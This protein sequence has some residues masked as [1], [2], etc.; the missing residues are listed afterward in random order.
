[1]KSVFANT[2]NKIGLLTAVWD[3]NGVRGPQEVLSNR[4]DLSTIAD[5]NRTVIAVSVVVHRLL[6]VLQTLHEG[7]EVVRSPTFRLEV[8]FERNSGQQLL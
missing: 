6:V 7:E 3:A 8:V 2:R 4:R 1:M 5:S